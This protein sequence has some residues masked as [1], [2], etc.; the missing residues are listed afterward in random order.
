VYPQPH[1]RHLQQGSP[2]IDS[3]IGWPSMIG[4]GHGQACLRLLAA[5]VCAEGA[6]LV[7]IDP[8]EDN[9]RGAAG[10]RVEAIGCDRSGPSDPDAV[11]ARA[12]RGRLAFA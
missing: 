11:R 1:L 2:A 5:R 3:F 12:W 9:A 10:F 8:G 4:R 7:A 6:P